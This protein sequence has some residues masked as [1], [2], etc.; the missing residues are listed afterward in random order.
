[1]KPQSPESG[2]ACQTLG[3]GERDLRE[4]S[5]GIKKLAASTRPGDP[6][7]AFLTKKDAV[8]F[9]AGDIRILLD[10]G[11][12]YAKAVRLLDHLGLRISI[13]TLYAYMN[14]KASEP[15]EEPA[16]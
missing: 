4:I 2:R 15:A 1:M 9:L 10:T 6:G 11:W 12:S 8:L 13:K 16:S 7:N 3:L 5:T 14:M